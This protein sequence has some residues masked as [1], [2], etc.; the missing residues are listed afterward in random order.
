[1]PPHDLTQWNLQPSPDG[2]QA[3]LPLS[4]S[5][6]NPVSSGLVTNVTFAIA[7]DLVTPIAPPELSGLPSL[8]L[9]QLPTA[10]ALEAA[11]SASFD[12]SLAA[13]TRRTEELTAL[14]I[15]PNIDP[16]TLMLSAEVVADDH[17]FLLMADRRG[18]FEVEAAQRAGVPLPVPPGQVFDLSEFREG[19]SLATFLLALVEPN[20]APRPAAA[21]R[22]ARPLFFEEV[23]GVFGRG[24]ALPVRSQLEIL[25]TLR[26]GGVEY[27]FAAARLHGRTFRGLLAGP[28]GKLW[29]ERFTLE[30]FPGARELLAQ[31]LG[32]L[33]EAIEVVEPGTE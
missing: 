25:I 9:T 11:L 28:Q 7:G 12:I 13:L 21:P 15:Q 24:A 3:E 17:R 33:P 20:A 1:M 29:A 22:A 5:L 30:V 26:A 32:V 16:T 14:G 31:A 4:A 18:H 10:D 23:A 2:T 19:R 8:N 6:I 27:R